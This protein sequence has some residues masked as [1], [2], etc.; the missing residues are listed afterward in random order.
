MP[1]RI[2]F[3]GHGFLGDPA[4]LETLFGA[5]ERYTLDPS[6]DG[7]GGFAIPDEARPGVVR[8]WGNFFDVSHAFCVETDDG[9]ICARLVAAIKEN[10]ATARY[11]AAKVERDAERRRLLA[12]DAKMRQ[13][14]GR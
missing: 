10:K 3:N 5:L 7:Y 13:R 8:F 1:T 2:H 6:F 14:L 4:S 12:H 9:E 11:A